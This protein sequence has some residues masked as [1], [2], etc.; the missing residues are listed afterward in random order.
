MDPSCSSELMSAHP[1]RSIPNQSRTFA[2]A[3]AESRSNHALCRLGSGLEIEQT[4]GSAAIRFDP[5]LS[6]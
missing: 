3:P 6:R 4:S 5:S 1:W 2:L